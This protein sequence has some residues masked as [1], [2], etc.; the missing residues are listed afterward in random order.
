MSDDD[1]EDGHVTPG[2]STIIKGQA[3][4]DEWIAP[5]SYAENCALIEEHLAPVLG[6]HTVLHEVVSEL[7]HLDVLV[8]PPQGD[9]DYWVYVTSGMGD[10]RMTMDD[11]A[12]AVEW[13]RAELMIGLPR[14]WGDKLSILLETNNFD[15]PD[16]IYWPIVLLKWLARYPHEASTWFGHCHT[17][18]NGRSYS[19][20]TRLDGAL[21]TWSTLLPD[22]YLT[23]K[24]PNGDHLNFYGITLLYPEEMQF[25]LDHGFDALAN[26]LD[27]VEASAVI[28]VT[29]SSALAP[30]DKKKGFRSWFGL[31][32]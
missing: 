3:R 22:E 24:L 28:D 2:G 11:E 17:I 1:F 16:D 19:E 30:S 27:D 26:K 21:V 14:D 20:H 6:E 25:K 8:Y 12:D 18:P 29:R 10:I 31:N 4:P 13:A 32:S 23:L 7:I 9:R 5:E 15:D